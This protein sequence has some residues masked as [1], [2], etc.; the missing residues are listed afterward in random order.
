MSL[1]CY[2]KVGRVHKD[3]MRMLRGCYKETAPVEFSLN[4][5]LCR[6][7][8]K[9]RYRSLQRSLADSFLRRIYSVGPA[10][11]RGGAWKGSEKQQEGSEIHSQKI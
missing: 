10:S 8:H 3:V 5:G 4:R 7:K 2:E 11:R 6:L 9:P 1:A